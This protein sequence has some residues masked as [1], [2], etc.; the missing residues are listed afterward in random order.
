MSQNL[1]SETEALS[2]FDNI[3]N[4]YEIPELY[5]FLNKSIDSMSSISQ[6]ENSP[7]DNYHFLCKNC[8]KNIPA[9]KF[10]SNN[11]IKF[12][13]DC[14][15]ENILIQNIFD[16]LYYSVEKDI[17]ELKCQ[18]HS[19]EKY[20]FYCHTCE[21]NICR[22][23]TIKH[24]GHKIEYLKFDKKAINKSK[25]IIEK[26]EKTKNF[27]DIVIDIE[28]ED[29]SSKERII[30]ETDSENNIIENNN[31]DKIKQSI[32]IKEQL[33]TNLDNKEKNEIIN[34]INNNE[35]LLDKNNLIKKFIK[36]I[37]DDFDDYPNY[38][39]I[40]IISNLEKFAVFNFKD[41]NEINLHYEINEENIKENK[42]E[43]FGGKFVDNNKE[44]CFLIINECLID[45]DRYINLEEIFDEIP[46]ERPLYLDVKLIE[47]KRKVMTNL[48][49]MFN[50][51]STISDKSNFDNYNSTKIRNMSNMFYNCKSLKNLPNISKLRTENVT[52][53]S[54]MF[55][56]CSSLDKIPDISNWKVENLIKVNNMFENC[57]SLSFFPNIS[58]WNFKNIKQMNYMFKNC[59][60]LQNIPED[61]NWNIDINVETSGIFEGLKVSKEIIK[62]ISK[63]KENIILKCSKKIVDN[64]DYFFSKICETKLIKC[65]LSFK[66]ILSK[67][68]PL[69][70]IFFIP[71]IS[72]YSM[73]DYD[74][75]KEI[76]DN[77]INYFESTNY[78]N[79][80]YLQ[81][82]LNEMNSTS[83]K[84]IIENKEQY[85]NS[86][87]NFTSINGN[88][89]FEI[90]QLYNKVFNILMLVFFIIIEIIL[91]AI[92]LDIRKNTIN[93]NKDFILSYL[94]LFFIL[95]VFILGLADF[96]RIIKLIY[97]FTKFFE[98]SKKIF[99]YKTLKESK[100]YYIFEDLLLLTGYKLLFFL[101][102]FSSF[103]GLV[104]FLANE[105]NNSNKL[106][107][108][109]IKKKKNNKN[110]NEYLCIML[111]KFTFF[112][113]YK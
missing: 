73:Y 66:Y 24:I 44:N 74:K 77:P 90:D 86:I 25:Y 17:K 37:L 75:L 60:S 1:S 103:F 111:F 29:N 4:N 39:H 97:S 33:K 102:L 99:N 40:E 109:I 106:E 10:Y 46:T 57:S 6:T 92:I 93:F 27:D 68:M 96:F 88:V 12:I 48:S 76:I 2:M 53:M 14:K 64:I 50:E 78:I 69:I 19:D 31:F 100:E 7:Y 81:S 107:N 104:G 47:R 26:E 59:K 72:I 45:L 110:N 35:Q 87:L 84:E 94:M 52:D 83:I 58:K 79:Y 51:I 91:L 5:N 38:K 42:I 56:N 23:C 28:S 30:D 34:I 98:I 9:L 11:K 22:K 61:L 55:S 80:T 108:Q 8:K 70:S 101:L 105:K 18:H 95:V 85:I 82:R 49:F 71:F 32:I 16:Y 112:C 62:K 15:Q 41:Y 65:Y 20:I 43:I 21:K 67:N 3:N 13:C 113:L 54:Y 89:K 36:T 63:K